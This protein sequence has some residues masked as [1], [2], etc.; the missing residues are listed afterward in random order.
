MKTKLQ[1]GAKRLVRPVWRPIWTAIER[2]VAE[3]I[4]A[5]VSPVEA[6]VRQVD[7]TARLRSDELNARADHIEQQ[8]Y[9]R[10]GTLEGRTDHIESRLLGIE[11]RIDGI[12]ALLQQHSEQLRRLENGWRRHSPTF[13]QA[14]AS[15][16]ALE[17]EMRML[18]DDLVRNKPTIPAREQHD[19]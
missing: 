17:H 4:D 5:R 10:A 7:A 18:R 9:I 6:T 8:L 12:D 3:M 11:S 19:A 13:V 15:V 2:S 16:V 1:N 14:V